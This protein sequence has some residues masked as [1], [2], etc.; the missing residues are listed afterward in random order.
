M[1]REQ[2]QKAVGLK[3]R[4]HFREAHL[5]PALRAGLIE[6]PVPD[7][8]RSRNQ[9]NRLTSTGRELLTRIKESEH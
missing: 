2:L 5:L 3:P 7:K 6:M 4:D 8:P 9:R 1:S